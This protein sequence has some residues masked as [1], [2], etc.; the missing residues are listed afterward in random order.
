M[1]TCLNIII[2]GWTFMAEQL[3]YQVKQCGGVI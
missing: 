3:R 1:D 2:Y